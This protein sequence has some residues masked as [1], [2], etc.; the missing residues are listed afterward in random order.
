MEKL[1]APY[2]AG[3]VVL[4][5]DTV[6]HFDVLLLRRNTELSFHG[7]AWVFPGG[8]IDPKDYAHEAEDIIQAARRAAVREAGEEADIDLSTKNLFPL[9]RWTTPEELPKRFTTWFFVTSVHKVAVKVDGRE[10][11]DYCWIPPGQALA[12]HRNGEMVLPPPTFVTLLR[13][14]KYRDAGSVLSAVADKP[15]YH[16]FPRIAQTADGTCFLYEGDAGYELRDAGQPGP[17]HRLQTVG[18]EWTYERFE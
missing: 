15:L 8:R 18:N 5:K 10:I 14:S 11:L 6:D 16:F 12:K 3:T 2:P 1:K 9:S 7:G 4:L 13:L 17:R